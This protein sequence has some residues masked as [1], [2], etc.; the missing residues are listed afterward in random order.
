MPADANALNNIMNQ[1]SV[2]STRPSSPIPPPK[3]TY[4][5]R[6]GTI[7]TADPTLRRRRRRSKNRRTRRNRRRV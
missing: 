5:P 6:S 3:P 4:R 2:M 1:V 7:N